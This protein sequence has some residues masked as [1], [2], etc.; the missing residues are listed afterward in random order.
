MTAPKQYNPEDLLG[1]KIIKTSNSAD[2]GDDYLL[3][4][5]PDG[6]K[7]EVTG[8]YEE[9]LSMYDFEED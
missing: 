6:R 1:G 8:Y 5:M 4:E 3:I 2:H 7:I 9:A